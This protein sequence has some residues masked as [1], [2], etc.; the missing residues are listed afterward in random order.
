MWASNSIASNSP[1]PP[2]K[3]LYNFAFF[4]AKRDLETV[5]SGYSGYPPE[6]HLPRDEAPRPRRALFPLCHIDM[7]DLVNVKRDERAAAI[8]RGEP[9]STRA[10]ALFACY[11][12]VPSRT[13]PRS[14]SRS[15][16]LCGLWGWPGPPGPLCSGNPLHD[17]PP[18]PPRH[19]KPL[20]LHLTV[21]LHGI[22]NMCILLSP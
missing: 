5:P 4:I 22:A 7:N 18:P 17:G 13:T 19:H 1:I 3:S 12:H 10:R 20:C 2:S 21:C 11:S 9:G 6:T 8:A 16:Y 14:R 15:A